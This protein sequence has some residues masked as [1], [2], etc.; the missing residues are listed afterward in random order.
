M[1]RPFSLLGRWRNGARYALLPKRS[2]KLPRIGERAAV[3]LQL[4]APEQAPARPRAKTGLEDLRLVLVRLFPHVAMRTANPQPAAGDIDRLDVGFV[5]AFL[6]GNVCE[7]VVEPDL[8]AEPVSVSIDPQALDRP[9]FVAGGPQELASAGDRRQIVEEFGRL[10]GVG[11]VEH[12]L[13]EVACR[14]AG[15]LRSAPSM[16]NPTDFSF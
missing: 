12:D 11:I 10:A 4:D 3:S 6:T 7:H 13:F 9:P 1:S 2:R 14:H 8:S 15:S 16:I 5:A